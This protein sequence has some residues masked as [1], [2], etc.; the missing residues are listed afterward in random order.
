MREH[1]PPQQPPSSPRTACQL[2]ARA[3]AALLA[4]RVLELFGFGFFLLTSP[5]SKPVGV[6]AHTAQLLF[7][8]LLGAK[9]GFQLLP[10]GFRPNV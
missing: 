6:M 10:S 7:A 8:S 3:I 4:K 5:C 1:D 2:Q 9:D